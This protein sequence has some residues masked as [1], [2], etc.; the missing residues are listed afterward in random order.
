M[1]I[2]SRW[3]RGIG[4]GVFDGRPVVIG[5]RLAY[6]AAVRNQR[7]RIARE[8]AIDREIAVQRENR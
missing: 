8:A 4:N 6:L 7:Q 3:K 1:V 5:I 2:P